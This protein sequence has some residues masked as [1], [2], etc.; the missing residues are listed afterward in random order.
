VATAV[1]VPAVQSPSVGDTA[2]VNFGFN[3]F[4]GRVPAII[5]SP[6]VASG[7]TVVVSGATFDHTSIIKTA[8]EV[9][10]LGTGSLTARDA[11]APSVTSASAL[12]DQANNNPAAFSGTIVASPSAVIIV[13][14]RI[15][16][17]TAV[18]LASAGPNI[19]LTA[20]AGDDWITINEI[21]DGGFAPDIQGWTI[22]FDQFKVGDG[23]TSGTLTLSSTSGDTPALTVGVSLYLSIL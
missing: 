20:T 22:G 17:Q 2:A 11:A 18:L 16:P 14:S 13:S 10:N 21:A 8:W 6:Y 15:D 19:T 7:S 1:S 4:G 23:F 3:A 12:G 9:F 5:V